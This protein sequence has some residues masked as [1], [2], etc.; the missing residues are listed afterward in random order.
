M[1]G[2]GGQQAHRGALPRT[3]EDTHPPG[4]GDYPWE[5]PSMGLQ[6]GCQC[7]LARGLPWP[8]ASSSCLRQVGGH[9]GTALSPAGTGSSAWVVSAGHPTGTLC[10]PQGGQKCLHSQTHPE[11]KD[12]ANLVPI[13]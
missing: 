6:Q 13:L 12:P 11:R 7:F 5:P 2:H 10:F 3:P 4:W 9:L 8:G 1:G